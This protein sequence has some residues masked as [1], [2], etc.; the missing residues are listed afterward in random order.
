MTLPQ[1]TDKDLWVSW[2][3][4]NGLIERLALQIHQA[5]WQFDQILCLARGGL[6]VGDVLSRIFD[7]PLAIL[8]ASSY[9]DASGTTQGAL[10]IAKCVTMMSDHLEGRVLVVDDM[11]DSGVTLE[12]VCQ[13]L[14]AQFKGITELKSGV[15]WFKSHSCMKPDFYVQR[16]ETNPWIHQPFEQ[17]DTLRPAALAKFLGG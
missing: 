5:G 8:L 11:V 2:D 3:E 6:R 1:S 13:H 14:S 7:K 9:R 10:D 12:R 4:Y 15:L 16:L 17:Y